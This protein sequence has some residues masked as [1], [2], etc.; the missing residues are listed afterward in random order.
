MKKKPGRRFPG[1]TLELMIDFLDL[2]YLIIAD[3]LSK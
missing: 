1:K 2:E 3:K